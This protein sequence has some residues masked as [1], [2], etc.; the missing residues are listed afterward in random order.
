MDRCPICEVA[1]RPENL[2]RHLN[3]IHPRHPDTPG[4]REKLREEP[5]R[6]ARRSAGPPIRVRRWQV[7]LVAVIVVIGVGAYVALQ[8]LTR[9]YPFGCITNEGGDLYHWHAN[10]EIFSGPASAEV[11][12]TI[13]PDVGRSVTC[14]QPLH[15]HDSSGQIHIESDVNRLFSL[16]DFFTVW[17]KSFGSP[18]LMHHNGTEIAPS[19]NMI[20]YDG[21]TIQVHYV[22]FTP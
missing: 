9:S 5:G 6:V 22:S 15:T 1:V 8:A 17:E 7:V 2:L 13:P 4:L 3:D 11:P 18:R 21:T 12:V 14:L 10:L 20:L 19:A 16:G